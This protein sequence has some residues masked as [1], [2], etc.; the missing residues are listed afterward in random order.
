M[1]YEERRRG[2]SSRMSEK[3]DADAQSLRAEAVEWWVRE[4]TGALSRAD[5]ALFDAWLREP[6]HRAAYEDIARFGDYLE[7]VAA[8][9]T[10]PRRG[11]VP[12]RRRL[13][14][15]AAPALALLV[16]AILGFHDLDIALRADHRAGVGRSELITL[17]DGSRVH[18]APRSAL[19]LRHVAGERRMEL[20]EGEAWFDVAPDPAHPFIVEAAGGTVRA[21]GTAFDVALTPQETRVAVTSHSVEIA[22]GGGR[23][24]VEEG[25]ESAYAPSKAA[26]APRDADI[27]R[28]TAW[29]RGKLIVDDEPLASVLDALA[30]YRRGVVFCLP[31]ALCAR[32]VSGVFA[33]DDPAQALVE[34]EA[35]L[36]LRATQLSALLVVLHE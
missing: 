11:S 23:V 28:A 27:A 19:A 9:A 16:A 25:R 3:K 24:V 20:L 35:F 10:A 21:L 15:F 5:R 26:Q 34:I 12:P 1:M 2:W 6:G 36:G 13:A 33:A 31:S 4:T 18:L 17:A 22:S 30:R 29:R 14:A 7:T 32:R 8:P